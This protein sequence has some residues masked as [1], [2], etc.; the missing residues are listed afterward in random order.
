M[1][2]RG[3]TVPER[4][5]RWSGAELFDLVRREAAHLEAELLAIPVAHERRAMAEAT[6]VPFARETVAA[7]KDLGFATAIWTNNDRV[8]ADFVLARFEL[9]P[10]LDLVVTRDEMR[11]LK[12]DPDGL[13]VVRGALA[14]RRSAS[15]S[16]ATPGWT[17]RRPRPPACPSSPTAPT[18]AEMAQRGVVPSRP[19][20]TRCSICPAARGRG[21]LRAPSAFARG[22]VRQPPS[23]A[24]KAPAPLADR[25]R[26]RS[27]DEV[28]GQD[29]PD[30]ARASS[31]RAAIE[32]GQ[33][34][35]MILWGPPGTGK[36]TL[37]RAH[38]RTWPAPASCAFSAVLS[39]VKEIRQVMA[40]AEAER[41]AARP[42]HD[43]VRRRD[44]P[45]QQGAAGRVPA[46]RREGHHRADRRHH[47]EPV[48]RGQRG[49]ALA[50]P[51]LRAARARR[52]RPARASCAARSRDRERGL[53]R[54]GAERRATTRSRS[55]A[56]LADGDARTRAQRARAGGELRRPGGA[57]SHRG[58]A[59]ARRRSRRRCSTTSRARS[60][61][62]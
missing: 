39:G 47:R 2:A 6:L 26:P 24:P 30:R 51:R 21:T 34:H 18:E 61:T 22:P 42:A 29:A 3:V 7:M 31:L 19:R 59:S 50:L 35:S 10:H 37:A 36:T 20:S 1:R 9:S 53:G 8:V 12:P 15:W 40:E 54:H 41:P 56:R 11:P 48:V 57:A 45:L 55:I 23:A 17:A 5:L 60:T 49:A 43:P 25:M 52:G 38:G 4:A 14:G 27:L 62:T 33:L 46:P 32:S 16:W 28:V 44:P 58:G 13:R